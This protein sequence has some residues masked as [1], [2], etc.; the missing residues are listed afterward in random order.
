MTTELW[1]FYIESLQGHPTPCALSA[2]TTEQHINDKIGKFFLNK[3][4]RVLVLGCGDGKEA[5]LFKN[6]GFND[7]QGITLDTHIIKD[8]GVTIHVRDMHNLRFLE[9]GSINYVYSNHS[10]EHSFAPFMLCLEV[11]TVMRP[12]GVWFIEYPASKFTGRSGAITDPAVNK[13]SHHHPNLL[14]PEEAECLFKTT[15]FKIIDYTPS[16]AETFVL[17][18]IHKDLLTD[19]GVHSDVVRTLSARLKL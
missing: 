12:G 11:W 5:R 15:G 18:R 1:N 13:V 3:D 4:G 14:R 19:Y 8:P 2:G 10:F 9:S 17:E 7:V 6:L 16:G